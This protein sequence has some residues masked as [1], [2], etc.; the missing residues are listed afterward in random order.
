MTA[1]SP[2]TSPSVVSAAGLVGGFAL[3][4]ATGRRAL[5]GVAFAVAGAWCARQW[6]CA[7]G[8]VPAAA[9]TAGYAA[10]MGVSHP[11]AK[12]LG[13]WPSVLLVSAATATA[14]EL[15]SRRG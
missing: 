10:A 2:L 3:G 12:K 8:P 14:S 9:L 6:A 13:P 4:R 5:G 11:L 15:V 7:S 1:L